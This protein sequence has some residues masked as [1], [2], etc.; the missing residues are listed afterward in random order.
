MT[1][2]LHTRKISALSFSV[3]VAAAS[4]ATLAF[5]SSKAHSGC[6]HA[7]GRLFNAVAGEGPGRMIG[8]IA[9]DY[10]IDS[11]DGILNPE[12]TPVTFLWNTSHV[13][14]KRGT[15]NFSEFAAVD[16][17]EQQGPNGAVLLLATGGTGKWENASGHITLSGFFHTDESTGEWD[18]E[19]EVC[20]P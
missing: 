18:Y 6:S 5:S 20:V 3:L 7:Q 14:G 16:F 4:L 1:T 9:G 13:E 15:L 8:T 11:F 19:G 12:G 2:R 17:T 10:W